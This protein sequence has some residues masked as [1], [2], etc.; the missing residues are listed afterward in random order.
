MTMYRKEVNDRSPMRIFERSIHGGL[1]LGNLG[2]IFSPPGVGKSAL[3]VQL[4]L[5]DLMRGR[6]VL[7][8]SFDSA[9]DRVRSFYDEIF[10]ELALAYQLSQPQE[11]RLEVERN[12]MIVS[13]LRRG[14]VPGSSP[15][16]SVAAAS[17]DD[18]LDK[19]AASV[20]FLSENAGFEPH[21]LV[22]DGFEFEGATTLD[23]A[24][25]RRLARDYQV[26][27]WLTARSLGEDARSLG[28]DELGEQAK[29][30]PAALERVIAELQVVVS[31]V[32]EA[33]AVRLSLVK[34]HDNPD[35][36]ALEL[37]LHPGT[38]R[39]MDS[40]LP[41]PPVAPLE[42]RRFH[43]F[44]GGAQGAEATFGACA[45]RWGVAETHFSFEGHPFLARKTGLVLLP[46][47]ELQRGNFSLV[48]A[49]HRLKRP[50]SNIPNIK[51]ILQAVWHQVTQADE[52]F[53]VGALQE[54]G[55]VR[56]GTG[57]GAELARLW[58][59]PVAVFDQERGA[60]FRWDM[61]RWEPDEAVVI[62]R[63]NF[64][65]VGTTRLTVDGRLA[66]EQLFARSFGNPV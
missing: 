56:G 64:A 53:I 66:I 25:L 55:T 48:Y 3:L 21:T 60:W 42:A 22:L 41:A 52:V 51:R 6:K 32:P 40:E 33:E 34:D 13:H 43:L 5:D 14:A 31:L 57:W 16:L 23:M 35:V 9:V 45:E 47:E 11:V 19:L 61:T 15:H 26:E 24:R 18:V 17:P 38:L 59:K 50:L 2:V 62:R 30:L 58:G 8:V 65:G 29:G 44:S 63:P 36:S 37:W 12:R 20:A 4:A 1:G 27:V 10:H 28:E 54:D 49:S 46:E 39:L 7:H